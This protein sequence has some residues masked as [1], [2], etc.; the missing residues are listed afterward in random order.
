[1]VRVMLKHVFCGRPRSGEGRVSLYTRALQPYGLVTAERVYETV[2]IVSYMAVYQKTARVE[3][4]GGFRLSGIV[5]FRS[6]RC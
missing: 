6:E 2:F 1:M 5:I 4:P 3:A